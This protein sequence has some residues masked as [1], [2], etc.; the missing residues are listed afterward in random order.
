M[1]IFK[2]MKLTRQSVILII[3]LI[4]C[5]I[6]KWY[7]SSA[8]R[9]EG[10][11]ST[12]FFP[13]FSGLLRKSFGWIGLSVG[14]ILYG[15]VIAWFIYKFIKLI[16]QLFQKDAAQLKIK[17][18]RNIYMIIVAG[19]LIYISFNLF[20]GINYNRKGIAFQLGLTEL[21]YDAKDLRLINQVLVQKVNLSKTSL[22]INKRTYP[23]HVALF[24]QAAKGYAG[25]TAARPY[26]QYE[27]ASLKRSLWG[28]FGNYAGFTG[29]YNPFTGE[30]Q[31]NT[32]VPQFLQPFTTSHEVAHQLGYAKELE[33]NFVGYL[34]ATSSADTLF[35]YSAYLELFM[36]ANRNLAAVDSSAARSYRRMLIQPVK[37]DINEWATFNKNHRSFMEPIFRWVYGKFLQSNEQPQGM[38]SYDEVTGLLIAYYKKYGK[39]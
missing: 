19:L 26:L 15:M 31:V 24:Q 22:V 3:L 28:W 18:R 8:T 34:A 14:D 9:V 6:L 21:K 39:I 16:Y 11:Y 17:V 5:L 38:L 27:P 20:W 12:R 1:L 23:S 33:A 2:V 7:S 32:S 35:H 29:Y 36:Y 4:I 25:L 37:T 13:S 10:Y 30:A